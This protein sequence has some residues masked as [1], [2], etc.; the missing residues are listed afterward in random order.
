MASSDNSRIEQTQ[1]QVNEVLGIMKNNVDKVLERD[2]KLGDLE[3]RAEHLTAGANQ[4]ERSAGMIK[5]KMWWKNVKMM[6]AVGV[7]VSIIIAV[8]VVI[9]VKT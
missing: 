5:K 3:D 4:F 1:N 7:V 9:A 8:I 2:A 6:I